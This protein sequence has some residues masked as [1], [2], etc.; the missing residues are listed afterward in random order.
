[1]TVTLTVVTAEVL[2][3]AENLETTMRLYKGLMC[4]I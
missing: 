2:L 1:M 4:L 3:T